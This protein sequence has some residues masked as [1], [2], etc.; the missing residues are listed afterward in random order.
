[1]ISKLT[2]SDSQ[3]ILTLVNDAAIA[4]KGK[5]PS[6]RWKEPYMPA[7]ELQE[8]IQRGLQFYGLK[9]NSVLVAVMGIQPVDDVTLI[10]HAYVL[11]SYQRKGYG[12]K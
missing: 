4:Y 10:R 1:M 8:E 3:A 12:E 5:I 7:Q 2:N 11:T 9:H 6:D